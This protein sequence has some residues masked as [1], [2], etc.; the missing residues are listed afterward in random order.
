[1]SGNAETDNATG[2]KSGSNGSNN[3]RQ[4]NDGGASGSG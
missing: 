4:S 1:M 2:A 3:G